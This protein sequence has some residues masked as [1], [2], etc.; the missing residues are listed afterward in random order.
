MP[1]EYDPQAAAAASEYGVQSDG[2]FAVPETQVI[3]ERMDSALRERLPTYD[4]AGGSAE[5]QLLEV[6][7]DALDDAW[8]SNRELFYSGYFEDSFGAHL[9]RLLAL[10][11]VQRQVRRGATGEVTF[12]AGSPVPSALTIPAGTTVLAPA[13]EDEPAIPFRTTHAARLA[14]GEQTAERVSIAALSPVET[15]LDERWLGAA[16]NVASGAIQRIRDPVQGI[17]PSGVTNPE[18]TGEAG[19]RADGSSYG[20]QRGVDRETDSE[21]KERYRTQLGF[22][23]QASLK[24]IRA[25]VAAMDVVDNASIEENVQME[26]VDGIPPKAFRV[27]VLAEQ[28]HADDIA[29]TIKDTASGGINTGGAVT[30]TAVVHGQAYDVNFDLAGQV[31]LSVDIAL[32]VTDEFPTDGETQ[33]TNAIVNYV[34]GRTTDGELRAGTPI[35]HDVSQGRIASACFLDDSVFEADVTLATPSQN[36]GQSNVPIGPQE[37]ARTVPASIDITTTTTE[38]P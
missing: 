16:T 6:F 33:I 9:D 32:Q 34:G 5:Q 38:V 23:G 35:G 3:F 22:G 30:G 37:V 21:L 17:P 20:F 19:T 4:P 11:G 15:D 2:S 18:P 8:Q 10:A 29:Q 14:A 13:T 7:A 26:A 24:N 25:A 36:Y 31:D 12:D 27:T 28:G 1:D